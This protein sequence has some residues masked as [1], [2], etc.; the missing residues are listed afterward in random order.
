MYF[1]FQFVNL[2]A[3][4]NIVEYEALVLRL[5]TALY[6]GAHDIPNV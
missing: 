4:N 3:S 1:T 6:L 5:S 2:A